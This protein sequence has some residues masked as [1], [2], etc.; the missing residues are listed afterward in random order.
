MPMQTEIWQ[1]H[2]SLAL[3]AGGLGLRILP[4][5]SGKIVELGRA[6]G[7]QNWLWHNPAMPWR[8]PQYGESFVEALDSGG[9]DEVFPSIQPCRVEGL[10]PVPDH[11]DPAGL[12]WETLPV[13]ADEVAAHGVRGRCADFSFRRAIAPAPGGRG[14][15]LRYRV[16]NHGAR[17]LPWLYCPHPLF[18]LRP[19][20]RLALPE[21][22]PFSVLFAMGR[23]AELTGQTRSWPEPEPGL[24]LDRIPD[25]EAPGFEPWGLKLFGEAGA[26]ERFALEDPAKGERLTLSWDAEALPHFSMWMNLGV[27]AGRAGL[28]PY[29]NLCVEP[30]TTPHEDL[31]RALEVGQ[32]RRLE[33]GERAEWWLDLT[34]EQT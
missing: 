19:G 30:T 34:I 2:E 20:M 4:A 13:E 14:L 21:G 26:T 27:W 25:F 11:G 18:D 24:R 6:G 16:E 31:A 23:A 29:V 1:G 33:P 8:E 7:G 32:G 10:A 5:C 9:W 17:A 3:E 12:G 22:L 15:R 28:K